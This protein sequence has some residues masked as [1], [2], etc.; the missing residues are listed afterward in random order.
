MKN[1][2]KI[3]LLSPAKNIEYGKTAINFGADAIYIGSPKFGAR[4]SAGNSITDIEKLCKYAHKFNAKVF[5]ALNTILYE[6][7]LLEAE[8]IIHQIYNAG[9]DAL[10]IQDMGI[11]E[12]NLPPIFLHASTQAHNF[13]GNKVAFLEKIGFKRAILARELSLDQIKHIKSATNIELE[14]FVHGA[15]CVSYSGQCYLSSY[16]GGR[17]GNRGECAQPCRLKYDLYD[18]NNKLIGADKHWLSIKDMNRANFIS[19]MAEAGIISFKIEGRLKD[20]NYVK[21]VTSFYR[22][23]IDN[24]LE[25]NTKYKKSSAGVYYFDFEADPEKSFNRRFIDYFLNGRKTDMASLSPKSVGKYLGEVKFV[26]E[27]Y[28]KINSKEQIINGDGLCSFKQNGDLIGWG[29]NKVIDDKIF[30]NQNI[31][32]EIGSKIY[33]NNDFEFNKKISVVENCRFLEI[34]AE[35]NEIEQGFELILKFEDVLAIQNILIEKEL[36]KNEEKS[37]LS[38]KN[39]LKK[40]GG[41]IFKIVNI[42]INLS[43]SYFIPISV[44]NE[45]RRN[46]LLLLENELEKLHKTE[47]YYLIKNNEAY[48]SDSVDYRANISNSLAE[49]FYKRHGVEKFENAFELS[50]EKNNKTV[51]TTKFCVKYEMGQCP[52]YQKPK[53]KINPSYLKYQDK[54]FTI[55]FDCDKC[56]MKISS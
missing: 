4:S 33:R 50:N 34:E 30:V 23:E 16:I 20:L 15:L 51:M 1:Q 53:N 38:I 6:N 5:V 18:K 13:D 9:A 42:N 35:F 2:T 44:L 52:K 8:K 29:V 48:F 19:D 36:A 10:I 37:L 24:F 26:G 32:V 17:S 41:T 54:K 14:A 39:Q 22:K 12:M 56:E 40:T 3:E 11:L 45:H 28:L 31:E 46:A 43:K 47:E 27:N 25:G 21:N 7:E 49:K 55:E